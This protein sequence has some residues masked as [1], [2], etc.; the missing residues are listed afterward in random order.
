MQIPNNPHIRGFYSHLHM[1]LALKHSMKLR[2]CHPIWDCLF[3]GDI[4]V[5]CFSNVLFFQ[6]NPFQI[7][8]ILYE[9]RYP[10]S[11]VLI[12]NARFPISHKN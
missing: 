9:Y 5:E 7:N 4:Q 6:E 3:F 2:P 11:V 1:L 10:I 8:E 12:H